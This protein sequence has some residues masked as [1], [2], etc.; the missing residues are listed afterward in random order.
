[1]TSTTLSTLHA[2][3]DVNDLVDHLVAFIR[4]WH[5]GHLVAGSCVTSS[6][7]SPSAFAIPTAV[8]ET[9]HRVVLELAFNGGRTSCGLGNCI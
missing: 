4:H 3:S 6:S 2:H 5:H 7:S 9:T 1:M 8:M